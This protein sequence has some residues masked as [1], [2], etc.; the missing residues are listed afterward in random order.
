MAYAE[1]WDPLGRVHSD[2]NVQRNHW[3]GTGVSWPPTGR[4]EDY[5]FDPRAG[6]GQ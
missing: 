2:G 5:D 3:G 1:D 4:N 6:R